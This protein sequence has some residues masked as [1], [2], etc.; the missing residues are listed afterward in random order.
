MTRTEA[1]QEAFALVFQIEAQGEDFP[2]TIEY[3]SQ[4][5]A[6]LKKTDRKQ[7]QYIVATA[8]NVY[9]NIE[10][11]D[12][13]IAQNLTADW[14]LERL[15]RASLGI[16]R[17]SVYEILFAEDV[18]ARVAA[19]EAVELAKRYDTDDAP[20]FINGVLSGVIKAQA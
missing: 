1:R 10:K 20:A 11:I 19:N 9:E 18:P 14:K 5:N 12:E 3:F 6:G 15:S 4:Q 16:L 8:Q 7:F 2:Q 13:I 17:L